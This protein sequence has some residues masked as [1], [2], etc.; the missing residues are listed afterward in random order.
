M[1]RRS[2][3]Q[4]S[5]CGLFGVLLTGVALLASGGS[6]I[7]AGDEAAWLFD[8]GA[9]VEVD[10]QL[11]QSSIDALALEP[12][13]YQPATFALKAGAVTFGPYSVGARLKGSAGSFRPLPGKAGLKVKF[14]E[15]VDDQT[16]FGLEKLTLNNMVQ[17]PSMVHETLSYSLFR[18]LGVPA[19]RTG[20]AFVRI[21]GDPYGVYLNLETLDAISL[22]RW[23]AST[24]HLYEG[25]A[26]LDVAPGKAPDF[27]VDEGKSKKREDLE[28]LILAADQTGGDWSDGMAAVADLTEMTRMWAAERYVGHWDGYAGTALVVGIQRPNNYY[29]HSEDTGTGAGVFQMLPWGTDQTW[30]TRFGFGAPAGGVLFDRCIE[31]ETCSGMFSAAVS[32]ASAAAGG[33][34]LIAR[35]A[36]TGAMLRPWQALEAAPRRPYDAAAI[37]AALNATCDFIVERPAEAKT[38]L[39]GKAQPFVP[40]GNGCPISPPP[41]DASESKTSNSEGLRSPLS[42]SILAPR[43][44]LL[45]VA[46]LRDRVR[47]RFRVDRAGKVSL[48][49]RSRIE[50]KRRKVCRDQA[51]VAGPDA[52]A[53]SCRL[54]PRALQ[55]LRQHS[56]PISFRVTFAP[57]RGRSASVAHQVTLPRLDS[58]G[59]FGEH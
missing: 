14:D 8:P 19:P 43:P 12:D 33:L 53:L 16:F 28:A 47:L 36:T 48:Q 49:G 5:F 45:S 54:S 7:A 17:D 31:D 29:L 25:Q 13:E 59:S 58:A 57:H 23:F 24:R 52:F 10:L 56:L 11:P 6:A 22:P 30:E 15:Y 44:R 26:G 20:Y 51:R 27:E 18:A 38:W 21:N 3:S 32:N 41:I 1:R 46:K 34:N 42:G 39:E 55:R 2:P 40:I 35:A 37:A 50:G 9:V 4:R